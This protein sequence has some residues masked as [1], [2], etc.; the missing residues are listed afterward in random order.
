MSSIGLVGLI[1]KGL[2]GLFFFGLGVTVLIVILRLNV[3]D[4]L[5]REKTGGRSGGW[6]SGSGVW[7]A[8][9]D[10]VAIV[11]MVALGAFGFVTLSHAIN[12]LVLGPVT[13]EA[14][15]IEAKT[16]TH[17]KE[18]GDLIL[19]YKDLKTKK[20]IK[21]T[22]DSVDRKRWYALEFGL[23]ACTLTYYSRSGVLVSTVPHGTKTIFDPAG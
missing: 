12:D 5:R 13:T 17:E 9:A 2:G 7:K 1:R 23:A 22:V 16:D 10:I 15:L 20:E 3:P 14:V 19:I 18:P 21:V 11:A 4:R 6:K 8:L